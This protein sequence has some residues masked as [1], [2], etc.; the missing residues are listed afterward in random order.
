M[1]KQTFPSF[2]KKAGGRHGGGVKTVKKAQQHCQWSIE[3]L[4]SQLFY[5]LIK[6]WGC[7]GSVWP[8]EWIEEHLDV[9]LIDLLEEVLDAVIVFG[10]V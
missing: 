5:P 1:A 7:D 9:E 6:G 2:G 10:G 8:V 4:S 3:I